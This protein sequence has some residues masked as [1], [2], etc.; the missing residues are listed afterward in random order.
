MAPLPMILAAQMIRLGTGVGR[1]EGKLLSVHDNSVTK[2]RLCAPRE[3][4]SGV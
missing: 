3:L 1:L 4:D 2:W